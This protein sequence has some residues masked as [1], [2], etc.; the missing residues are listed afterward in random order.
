M[1]FKNQ[2]KYFDRE[3]GAYKKYQLQ[4]WR[5][6]Y[7]KRIFEG[8]KIDE[9]LKTSDLY[10]D[11][12]VGGSGYTI[13]E[14]GKKGLKSIGSD[15]S[16]IGM[17]KAK[18]FAGKEGV[19]DLCSFVV[20]S[21]EILPFKN[22]CFTKISSIAVLEHIPADESAIREMVRITRKEGLVFITVPNTYRRM[23]PL[24]WL[25]YKIHDKR[26][27]HLRHYS[28]EELTE[29]FERHGLIVKDI[30][31]SGHLIK[32]IQFAMFNLF[33]SLEKKLSWIWW[34]MEVI[35]LRQKHIKSGLHLTLVAE[36]D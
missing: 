4:N 8:L 14:A 33:S 30:G 34:K 32:I 9:N 31:Y 27:G 28:E 7:I 21:A 13:I 2:K 24:F 16:P 3:F 36:K 11:I 17:R 19:E 26:V 10:L 12:G 29:K 6:S 20:C 22:S 23:W 25:P 35:D 18:E 1:Q 15:I 5:I